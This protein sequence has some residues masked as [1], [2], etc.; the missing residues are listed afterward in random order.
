MLAAR[1]PG[2]LPALTAAESLELTMIYSV[3]G[4]LGTSGLIT[5]RPFRAPHHAT[6]IPALVGGTS[7][8]KP[9]E[10][11]L[12]HRGV[13]FLD[14]LPEFSRTTLESLRQ[15]LETGAVHIS[16]A[17]VKAQYPA[18]VQL[19]ASLNPCRCG[20]MDEPDRRCSRAPLCGTDYQA[21]LSGPLLDRIDLHVAVPRL[22]IQELIQGK[23]RGESSATVALRVQSARE[24]QIQ[25]Y[26]DSTLNASATPQQ[27]QGALHEDAETLLLQAAE[28][29]RLSGRGYHRVA[30]I[31]RTIAD[32]AGSDQVHRAHIA[33][34]LIYRPRVS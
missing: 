18:R 12:A 30:R 21:R 25:R 3:A 29:Y 27:L 9:G 32:L 19:V 17:Q 10:I 5:H 23:D 28:T 20:F 33:E 31:G 8:A 24:R 15:P 11:S 7:K 6:S 13:L 1:L 4:L 14:E 26:S 16:R 34:A 22:P 2:L